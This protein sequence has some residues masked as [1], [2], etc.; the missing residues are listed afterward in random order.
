MLG[1]LLT[2]VLVA[3]GCVVW[4]MREA[5]QNERMAIRQ[6]LADAYVGHLHLAAKRIDEEWARRL[7]TLDQPP[8]GPEQFARGVR[9]GWVESLVSYDPSGRV[10]YPSEAPLAGAIEASPAEAQKP[11]TSSADPETTEALA[12]L[13]EARALAAEKKKVAM[14]DLVMEKF[15]GPRLSRAL[16][17]N[18]RLIAGNA[19]LLALESLPEANDERFSEITRRLRSRVVDYS[20]ANPLPSSQRRFLMRKLAQRVGRDPE[21]ARFLAAEDVA[22]RFLEA[23]SDV[24]GPA[25]LRSSA[26]AGLWKIASPGSRAMALFT[27]AG[28]RDHLRENI[29]GQ[30]LPTEVRITVNP[31]G[32]DSSPDTALATIAAGDLFPD[33]RLTL[34]LD[35][36]RVFD[37]LANRKTAIY[38]WTALLVIV[39][40]AILAIAVA[41]NFRRQVRLTQLKNDLV[42]TVSHELKTPLTSMRALVDTLLD[43]EH[44]NESDTREYLVLVAR[45]NARLSRLIENFLTFSKLE[46]KNHNFEFVPTN[47]QR[48]VDGAVSAFTERTRSPEFHLDVSVP[49]GLPEIRADADA[50]VTALL[51]LLD[52]AWKYSGNEKRIALRIEATSNAIR[53]IVED[54]GV[55]L[56]SEQIRKV[57]DRFYQA[58]RSLARATGGVGLGL[59]IAHDIVAAHRGTLDVESQPGQGSAFTI[60]IPA[61]AETA[62]AAA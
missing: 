30:A 34:H 61:S 62:G 60:E 26:L 3:T 50:L 19:E 1:F 7:R 25:V 40:L 5:M 14:A 44:F 46:R 33:W 41:T 48:I 57:F 18:G 12:A 31:S 8:F 20:A 39:A 37:N 52:N 4:F 53:F 15:G 16:D 32:E 42:A 11:E 45:E 10:I 35:D 24:A 9:E 17:G 13:A 22:A 56:S 49:P 21:L 23:E 29:A 38:L 55:G 2:A 27:T 59:S 58:D 51:N 6:K 36:R 28:L 47:P 43:R 54:H